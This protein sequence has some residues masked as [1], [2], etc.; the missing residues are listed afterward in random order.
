MILDHVGK[1]DHDDLV[2]LMENRKSV[3]DTYTENSFKRIFWDQQMKAASYCKN[4][5]RWHPIIIKCCLYLQYLSSGVYETLRTLGLMFGYC[6]CK[7]CTVHVGV[8]SLPSQCTLRLYSL[9]YVKLWL[10]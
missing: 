3:Y 9:Q 1:Q 4:S 7:Y 2:Q 5:M 6:D 10:F 8:L